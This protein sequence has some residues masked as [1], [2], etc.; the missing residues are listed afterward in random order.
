MPPVEV[1]QEDEGGVELPPITVEA[2][3]EA[4]APV[5]ARPTPAPS[6]G[7]AQVEAVPVAAPVAPFTPSPAQNSAVQPPI[8]AVTPAEIERSP[9]QSFGD[10]FFDKPGATS[11]TFAPGAS[12]PVLRGLDGHR[13]DIQENGLGIGDVS[14]LGG[15]HAVPIDPLAANRVEIIRGPESLRYSSGSVGGVVNAVSGR[16][17]VDIA[18]G[19]T[20]LEAQGAGTTVDDGFDG[21]VQFE[22]RTGNVAVHVDAYGRNAEDYETPLGTQ[23]NSFVETE[24]QSA[25]ATLFFDRGFIG[26]SVS[27]F[28]SDYGIPGGEEAELGIHIDMEQVRWTNRGAYRPL[29]GPVSEVRFWL[30]YSDYHHDEI[31]QEH[32]HAHEEEHEHEVGEHHDEHEEHAE[33]HDHGEEVVHGTFAQKTWEARTE[34]Q[35]RT[36]ATGLGPVNGLLGFSWSHNDL[37]TEGEAAEFLA[38]NTTRDVAAY[39][40]EELELSDTLRLQGAAR[41]EHRQVDGYAPEVP[42]DLLPPPDEIPTIAAGRDFTPFSASIG[43]ERDLPKAMVLRADAE[44]S[45]RAPTAAELFSKGSHHASGTFDIGDP[46][47]DV[48]TAKSIEVG[49]ERNAGRFRFDASAYHTDFD[50]FIF[51][52]LTGITCNEKFESCG[53]KDGEFD[54]VIIGQQDA[55]FTGAELQGAYDVT[56]IAGGIFGVTG[57][58]DFVYAKFADGTYVPRI[59]PHRLGGGFYWQDDHWLARVTLLHAFAQ[60]EVGANEFETPAYDL[61]NASLSWSGALGQSR[62]G[63]SLTLGIAADNLLDDEIRNAASFK[64]DEVLLPGRSFRLFAKA[65]F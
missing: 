46:D 4:R 11:S 64:A 36:V 38:P 52:Q 24:G 2:P 23:D 5:R 31:G 20:R 62:F 51:E 39:L 34:F 14:A 30:G 49:I 3:S 13:V 48:E 15:D 17:P 29:G 41:L 43:L 58:Y 26:T 45:E 18:P 19:T 42:A 12:R 21:A 9:A 47:L 63:E 6:A 25:G 7:P 16:I 1:I 53:I 28:A 8:D 35:Q 22:N 65:A 61:L 40:F 54:Q 56:E 32:D 57:R 50:G 60:D 10:L 37:Q 44:Y 59:P 33:E 55:T 27:R